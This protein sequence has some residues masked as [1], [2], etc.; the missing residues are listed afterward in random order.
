MKKLL[1][2]PALFFL[3]CSEPNLPND[4]L[5]DAVN[6]NQANAS[7]WR[8]TNGGVWNDILI[9]QYESPRGLMGHCFSV[10]EWEGKLWAWDQ[11]GSRLLSSQKNEPLFIARELM[12]NVV[13]A[14]WI[15]DHRK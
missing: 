2:I 8:L 9:V 13:W 4:C 12:S 15:K 11:E 14:Y 3:G 1:L 5:I 10:F 6:F 7:K